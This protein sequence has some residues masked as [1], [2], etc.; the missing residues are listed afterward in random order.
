M[1]SATIMKF[2]E[3]TRPEY[4][5][6]TYFDAQQVGQ[7]IG[8]AAKARN[9]H[10]VAVIAFEDFSFV[11]FRDG[12]Q[13]GFGKGFAVEERFNG[14]QKDFGPLLLRIR[15]AKPD[16]ILI[17]AFPGDVANIL[18]HMSARGMDTVPLFITEG[19]EEIVEK[20]NEEILQK[21]KAVS[22]LGSRPSGRYQDF[23]D[24]YQK[25]FGRMPRLD[26]LLTYEATKLLYS[27]VKQCGATEA[28]CIASKVATGFDSNHNKVYE[29]PLIT[30][31]RGWQPCLSEGNFGATGFEFSVA[32]KDLHDIKLNWSVP[33]IGH[34]CLSH[35]ER[36]A[37]VLPKNSHSTP[38]EQKNIR[39]R[40]FFSQ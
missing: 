39:T 1:I 3:K 33:N 5:F 19:A 14:D 36:S 29:V 7:Q 38:I 12:F 23:I 18:K 17:Y 26:A 32:L 4:A 13:A 28:T 27:A 6:R 24:R 30:Y 34:P 20:G 40:D 8:G 11:H 31:D 16:A 25:V 21:T 37:W 10:R 22:Y 9:I 35:K 15:A 2:T